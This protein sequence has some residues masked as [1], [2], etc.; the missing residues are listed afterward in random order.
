MK[1]THRCLSCHRRVSRSGQDGHEVDFRRKQAFGW[2]AG[3]LAGWPALR[4]QTFESSLLRPAGA[5]T[6]FALAT[7]SPFPRT[8]TRWL[9]ATKQD[10]GV[11]FASHVPRPRRFIGRIP[12]RAETLFLNEGR[13]LLWGKEDR[14]EWCSRALTGLVWSQ[15]LRRPPLKDHLGRSYNFLH[16]LSPIFPKLPRLQEVP[17]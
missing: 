6:L 17:V 8:S 15:Q 10:E 16:K 9:S 3:L 1:I 2:L 14:S 12:R 13:F 4:G 5:L 7:F 11:V